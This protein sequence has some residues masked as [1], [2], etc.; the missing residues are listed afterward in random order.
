MDTT[1]HMDI[2]TVI[3]QVV[4]GNEEVTATIEY[5]VQ[6]SS[7]KNK[8]TTKHYNFKG[9]RDVERVKVEGFYK[10]YYG[11]T[12]NFN[13]AKEHLKTAKKKGYK[14]AFLVAFNNGKKISVQKAI[15]MQ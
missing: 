7:G 12:P 11:T 13:E 3:E 8:I 9:L 2:N 6:I 4:S 1:L 14:T 10:Y 15:K 5:K